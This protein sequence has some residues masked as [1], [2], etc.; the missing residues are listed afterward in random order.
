MGLLR[1]FAERNFDA[2]TALAGSGPAFVFAIVEAM[3]DAGINLGLSADVSYDLIKQMVG[4]AMTMLYEAC[5]SPAEL[6]LKVCSPAGT[7]IAGLRALEKHGL[8]SA[9]IE[10]FLAT[11]QRS[12][13][14]GR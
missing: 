14:L 5:E 8:R 6:R 12:Q 3:V 2:V 4:G 9:L 11:Y 7:T 10:T 1:W 13:E